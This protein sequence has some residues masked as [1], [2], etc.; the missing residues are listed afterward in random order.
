[1]ALASLLLEYALG[2]AAQARGFSTY[3]TSLL[4]LAPHT[5]II[6]IGNNAH[7]LDPLVRACPHVVLFLKCCL[8]EK[9]CSL[10]G[11]GGRTCLQGP[12]VWVGGMQLR[13]PG[14][15]EHGGREGY[16]VSC[17]QPAPD[18]LSARL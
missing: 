11:K 6:E 7:T 16:A 2:M 18:H 17:P 5:L 12:C 8:G 10:C 13:Y 9:A 4:N 1:M 15:R 3:L 14:R